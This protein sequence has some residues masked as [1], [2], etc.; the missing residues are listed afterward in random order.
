VGC[1]QPTKTA[2]QQFFS[3]EKAAPAL[4]EPKDF[5]DYAEAH[6]HGL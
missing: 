6:G 4:R 2:R 1:A 5:G 3:E